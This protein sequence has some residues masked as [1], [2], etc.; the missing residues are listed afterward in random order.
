MKHVED[1]KNSLDILTRNYVRLSDE[2]ARLEAENER[3]QDIITNHHLVK[4]SSI[5]KIDDIPYL[6]IKR[7]FEMM[8]EGE[9]NECEWRYFGDDFGHK[10]T[11]TK[12]E[13]GEIE[14]VYS[15]VEDNKNDS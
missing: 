8:K 7:H 3:L 4:K 6:A 9:S 12:N 1:L 10:A 2:N 14:T 5:A 13:N 15:I 11:I